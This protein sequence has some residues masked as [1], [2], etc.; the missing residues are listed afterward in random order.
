[1]LSVL[2]TKDKGFVLM[3]NAPFRVSDFVGL[4]ILADSFLLQTLIM[5]VLTLP[6]RS[7]CLLWI[8]MAT[9]EQEW[10]VYSNWMESSRR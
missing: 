9:V 6:S 8:N 7:F 3:F 5:D 2:L 10:T 1:M 4:D